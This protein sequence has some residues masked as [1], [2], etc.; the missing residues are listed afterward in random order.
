MGSFETIRVEREGAVAVVSMA[1][2]EKRNAM[3]P[4]M[5][6][7]LRAALAEQQEAEAVAAVVLT[8]EGRAFSA[9][10]D[11]AGWEGLTPEELARVRAQGTVARAL[12][13]VILQIVAMSKPVVAAING[14]AIGGGL[15]LAIS[16]DLRIAAQ[17]AQFWMPEAGMGRAIGTPSL[18][19]LVLCTG[20]LIAKDIVLTGRRFSAADLERCGLISQ[21]LPAQDVLTAA[22]Q[23]AHALTACPPGV[24]SSVKSRANAA[25]KEIWERSLRE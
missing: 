8:G 10:A 14:P 18:E 4:Q 15:I 9:G 24:M 6:A 11:R 22:L 5:I 2:P 21:T 20:P 3:N 16:C 12:G 19:T 13:S 25:M 1:R 23:Q 17:E 7:E